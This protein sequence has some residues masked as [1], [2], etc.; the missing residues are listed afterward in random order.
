M[1]KQ[2][3]TIENSERHTWRLDNDARK[4]GG[5][6]A[7]APDEPVVIRNSKRLS[8]DTNKKC[9]FRTDIVP[10]P[11]IQVCIY[12]YTKYSNIKM[13][14][15]ND[16]LIDLQMLDIYDQIKF[17]NIDGGV[18]KQGWT[19]EYDPTQ[20]NVHNKLKVFV[21][22]HSHN[23][24]GWIKTF[25]EY[26]YQQTKLILQNALTQLKLHPD[27][28]FIW[29]EISYFSRWFDALTLDEQYDVKK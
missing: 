4:Q 16:R 15:S 19:V 9:T 23:D 22:P 7:A 13:I 20:W 1:Q 14:N 29:A 28:T 27:M 21:V 8:A 3:D 11:D 26:Y 10:T 25:D 17:D 18:W 5:G 2:I 6:A 24:P 12:W